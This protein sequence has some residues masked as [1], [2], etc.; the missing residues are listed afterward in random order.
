MVQINSLLVPIHEGYGNYLRQTVDVAQGH[1]AT[2]IEG[3]VV[4]ITSCL[5]VGTD[6]RS[7]ISLEFAIVD[8]GEGCSFC[9][10]LLAAVNGLLR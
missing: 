7:M 5:G 4:S 8:E 6:E 3:E 9:H 2:L 1:R 10:E